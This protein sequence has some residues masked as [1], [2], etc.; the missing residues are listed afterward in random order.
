MN[1][2]QTI[3]V[4]PAI[5]SRQRLAVPAGLT[6]AEIADL[7]HF[8]SQ[9]LTVRLRAPAG[10]REEWIDLPPHMWRHVRP[11]ADDVVLFG[12]RLQGDFFQSVFAVIAAVA[13]VAANVFLTPIIGAPLAALAAGL[14]GVGA[15][16]AINAL[17]PAQQAASSNPALTSVPE[18]RA[19]QFA[20]VESDSNVLVRDAFLPIVVGRR[21][22]LLPEIAN[23]HFFLEEGVQT[24]H[25]IFGIDGHHLI[26]SIQVDGTPIGDFPTITTQVRDGAETS[27]VTTF[28]TKVTQPVQIG[29]TLS[30]F[31]LDATVLVDQETPSNSEPQPV[32]FTTGADDSMEEIC[33][34]LQIDSFIKSDEPGT[35]IRVPV[36]IRFRPKGSMGAWFNL[37]EI[38]FGGRDV[39]TTL[40]EIRLRWDNQFGEDGS[41]GSIQTEFFQ[42]VPAAAFT[43]SNG[44]TG[45][46]WQAD[47]AFVS[48]SGLRDTA[49]IVGRRNGIRIT[50]D[51]ATYPRQEYEWEVVRGLAVTR[52][53]LDNSAYTIGGAV[54]S[55]FVARSSAGAWNVP[56]DQGAYVGRIA[57]QQATVVVNQQPCQRPS[58]ALVALKSK[59]Q[60]VRGV[61][62]ICERYVRDWNGTSWSTLTT[63]KNPATHFRQVLAD[64]LAYHGIDQDLIVNEQFVAWRA[65]CA[66][67]GYEVSGVFA[68]SSVRDVLESIAVAGYAR[69]V[70]SDVFGVDYFRDR[71]GDRP[72]QTFSPRNASI[73]AEWV[74]SERLSGIAATFQNED[75]DFAA[76]EVFVGNPF[77]TNLNGREDRNYSS[78]SKRELVQRRA[79][80]D[81]LQQQFQQRRV[82]IVEAATE[83]LI[84]ERGD[85]VAIITDLNNDRQTGARIRRVIDGTTFTYD[86][87]VP[88]E[89]TTDI[90]GVPNIFAE[91]DIFETG[92]QSLV[93]L[94]TK[95]HGSVEATIT[96]AELNT[97]DGSVIVI[98]QPV[99]TAEDEGG[100]FLIGPASQFLTRCIVAD[101]RRQGQERAQLV[102]V[103]EAPEIWTAMQEK[104]G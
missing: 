94:Q 103:D 24:V 42:R 102:L 23:P 36:R 2:I 98:D 10:H 3:H 9:G 29:E 47:A 101:V 61:S 14:L 87:D 76:D 68:G 16:L 97:P 55:L 50:L 63:T 85:L 25:R 45:D 57:L 91:P 71:S 49:N 1:T 95:D 54:N 96:A 70:F 22:I 11:K 20:T 43:L 86:Q 80:F 12:Y 92:E 82:W 5:G 74:S 99:L 89:S 35:A 65:E 31:S 13:V 75:R 69:P 88:T 81:I 28:V 59:G 83:A 77:Y 79:Y 67:R 78:I 51:P 41:G 17:F 100:H 7:K 84:C 93:L 33:I 52:A 90:F 32:R 21:R 15:S 46:Q 40:K 30:T 104:F 66:A 60:N 64:Y 62:A 27:L 8:G 37:P 44:A 38:H 4:A 72:V 19:R 56:V 34:R 48:G 39:S 53:G 6:V 26:S 18:E 58:T 73:T